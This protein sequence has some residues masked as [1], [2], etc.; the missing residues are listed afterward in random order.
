MLLLLVLLTT[1]AVA[2]S[3]NNNTL[4]S[5]ESSSHSLDT[6]LDVEPSTAHSN[7][8]ESNLLKATNESLLSD[9]AS[10]SQ[11]D[12]DINSATGTT[13]YLEKNYTIQDSEIA[14]Y[15]NGIIISK[16][17]IIIDGKGHTID[18]AGAVRIFDISGSGVTLKNIT[19]I[20][21]FKSNAYNLGSGI[22]WSGNS[23][24][25]SYCT[26]INN[27]GDNVQYP[28]SG[29]AI[30]WT[31]NDA[32][33]ERSSFINNRAE[34]GGAVYMIGDSPNI[35]FT[36]FTSNRAYYSGGAI[37]MTSANGTITN[38]N[39]VSNRG[40]HGGAIWFGNKKGEH[41]YVKNNVFNNNEAI[42]S[43]GSIYTDTYYGEISNN[44]FVGKDQVNIK[45]ISDDDDCFVYFDNNEE[46]SSKNNG[47][48]I[49]NDGR[50]KLKDNKFTNTI[51]NTN[52]IL[53][54][55]KITVTGTHQLGYDGNPIEWVDLCDPMYVK[56]ISVYFDSSHLFAPYVWLT[57]IYTTDLSSTKS[58]NYIVSE[59]LKMDD[60]YMDVITRQTKFDTNYTLENTPSYYPNPYELKACNYRYHTFTAIGD[61]GILGRDQ[62]MTNCQYDHLNVEVYGSYS[63]L[64]LAIDYSTPE[65]YSTIPYLG[66]MGNF[67]FCPEFDL[68]KSNPYYNVSKINFADGVV[69]NKTMGV[70][71]QGFIDG[72]NLSRM[73][74][75]EAD[76]VTVYGILFTFGNVYSD[77]IT[78]VEWGAPMGGALVWNGANGK[79]ASSRFEHNSYDY[80][81]H[82]DEYNIKRPIGLSLL[83]RGHNGTMEHVS[84]SKHA[85]INHT[86]SAPGVCVSWSGDNAKWKEITLAS[87]HVGTGLALYSDNAKLEDITIRNNIISGSLFVI[88]ADNVTVNRINTEANGGAYIDQGWHSYRE[89]YGAVLDI[90]DSYNLVINNLRSTRDYYSVINDE[91]SSIIIHNSTFI[92]SH[93]RCMDL[94]ADFG[95]SHEGHYDL[96]NITVD[97]ASY[98]EELIYSSAHTFN[99]I[100]IGE[101]GHVN[102]SNS[103]FSNALLWGHTY[104]NYEDPGHVIYNAGIIRMNNIRIWNIT[105]DTSGVGFYTENEAYL[106]NCSF[107]DIVCYPNEY[108]MH[109]NDLSY[110]TKFLGG[111]IYIKGYIEMN[112][113]HVINSN[114]TGRHG[115]AI[116]A[117]L[118]N[119]TI[120]NCTFFN[121]TGRYG[122]AIQ[123]KGNEPYFIVF[124]DCNFTHNHAEDIGGAFLLNNYVKINNCSF[125]ENTAGRNGIAIFID[126]GSWNGNVEISNSSFIHNEAS[127]YFYYHTHDADPSTVT[128]RERRY[129]ATLYIGGNNVN[130]T[131]SIF[132]NN[133]TT[134]IYLNGGDGVSYYNG[135]NIR[136]INITELNPKT[137]NK[138]NR[139]VIRSLYSYDKWGLDDYN[140]YSLYSFVLNGENIFLSGNKLNNTMLLD[141]FDISRWNY[142]IGSIYN[143]KPTI[144]SQTH[145][146][147]LNNKTWFLPKGY[148][149]YLIY[150]QIKDD[151]NNTIVTNSKFIFADN[152]TFINQKN[153]N[154]VG[155][156]NWTY[157]YSYGIYRWA[158]NKVTNITLLLGSDNL[159]PN[160]RNATFKYGVLYTL[161]DC[162]TWL[163]MLIDNT[164]DGGTLV[165][166]TSITFDPFFDLHEQNPYAGKINFTNGVLINKTIT[167]SGYRSWT[168]DDR[169]IDG[170][171]QAR[172]F[173]VIA[174][175][176]VLRDLS[177][178]N[179]NSTY[180]GAIYYDN[181]TNATL[182][183]CVFRKNNC[184]N[185]SGGAI[186]FNQTVNPILTSCDFYYNYANNGSGGAIYFNNTI[187]PKLSGCDFY[188]NY[189]INGSGG[190]VYCDYVTNL[191]MTNVDFSA[192]R[193]INGSGGA[194][195][196]NKSD[197][198]T[199]INN[200]E[201]NNNF[202]TYYGGA[203][204]AVNCNNILFDGNNNRL[205]F[206]SNKAA[207]GSA[208]AFNNVNIVKMYAYQS[209]ESDYSYQQYSNRFENNAASETGAF[210]IF[211]SSSILLHNIF[212]K[213]NKALNV[214]S[215]AI[216]N[217]KDIFINRTRFIDNN[218]STATDLYV[219]GDNVSLNKSAFERTMKQVDIYTG[220]PFG[221]GFVY[222]I[223]NNG[224]IN[225]TSFLRKRGYEWSVYNS[226]TRTY[227]YYYNFRH[228]EENIT[229]GDI[230]IWDGN[231]GTVSNCEFNFYE[232]RKGYQIVWNG[233][234][235]TFD[236]SKSSCNNTLYVA[237]SLAINDNTETVGFYNTSASVYNVGNISLNGNKFN[238]IIYNINGKITSDTYI[239]VINNKTYHTND[240]SFLLFT[241]TVDDM[242]N[243][244]ISNTMKV[245]NFTTAW[246]T[247]Y[248]TTH[249]YYNWTTVKGINKITASD[250]G[251]LNATVKPGIVVCKQ[252]VLLP[253]TINQT[254]EGQIVVINATLG[255][256]TV[257]DGSIITISVNGEEYNRTTVNNSAILTLYNLKPGLYK[258]VASYGGNASVFGVTNNTNFTVNLLN[259]TINITATNITFYG[260][261][262][263]LSYV[264]GGNVT[265]NLTG[266]VSFI[267]DDITYTVNVNRTSFD[268][269]LPRV[270]KFYITGIYSG[271][272][273]Y[274]GSRNITSCEVTKRDTPISI[275]N[276]E[277][278]IGENVTLEVVID[279]HATGNITISINGVETVVNISSDHVARLNMSKVVAGTYYVK[280]TYDGNEYCKA[281]FTNTT[282]IVTKKSLD[283]TLNISS[284]NITVVF[285]QNVTGEVLFDINGTGYWAKIIDGNAT[286]PMPDN[287]KP[288]WYNVTAEFKGD[289]IWGNIT[290]NGGFDVTAT[291]T[292]LIV[293]GNNIFAGD[294]ETLYI[295]MSP[296]ATGNVTLFINDDKI[297][298]F[299]NLTSVMSYTIPDLAIGK[300]DVRVEYTGDGKFA[301][302]NNITSFTVSELGGFDFIILVNDTYVGSKNNVTVI[303]PKNATGNITIEGYAPVKIVN[304]T[305]TIELNASYVPGRNNFVVTYVPDAT[306]E[307]NTTSKAAFYHVLKLNS[308]IVISNINITDN[309]ITLTVV[310]PNTNST[311]FV[312]GKTYNV[313]NGKAVI[314]RGDL[315]A[316]NH[317]VIATALEDDHY[318]SSNNITILTLPKANLTANITVDSENITVEFSEDV[319][320]EVLFDINGTH[321]WADII[322]NKAIIAI[323]DYLSPGKYN[324]TAIFKGNAE[325]NNITLYDNFT[326]E[327]MNATLIVIGSNIFVGDN[328]TLHIVVSPD[329]TGNITLYIND[330]QV[331]VFTELSNV[332]KYP[333]GNLTVGSYDVKVVYSGNNKY[334]PGEN[335]TS[336]TVFDLSDN[337][338]TVTIDDTYVG[339][340][341]NVT[342]IGPKNAT[343]N[344]SID[345]YGS[346]KLVDGKV[347]IEINGTVAGR[348]KVILNYVPDATSEYEATSFMGTFNVAKLNSTIV[349]SEVN[350]DDDNVTIV[351]VTPNTNSTIS[352]NG[353]KYNVSGGKVVIPRNELNAGNHTVIAT[354]LEDNIYLEAINATVFNIP[355]KDLTANITVDSENITVEFS[356]NIDGE[357]L[358]DINGTHIWAHIVNGKAIIPIPDTL[359][360]G[361]YNV[362]AIFKGND[363]YNNITLSD[364]FKLGKINSTIIP[365]ASDILLG[366]DEVIRIIISPN[367]T[368]KIDLYVDN[369]LADTFTNLSDVITYSLKNLE[370]GQHDI[371]VVYSGDSKYYGNENTTSFL[372]LE[373]DGFYFVVN[374]PDTPVGE[375]VN[376]TVLVPKN[377]TGNISIPGYD[378]VTIVDGKAVIQLN[379]SDDVGRK[380]LNVT[381]VPDAASEYN[382][383]SKLVN[384][385]IIKLTPNVLINIPDVIKKGDEV[386]VVISTE[387][388]GNVSVIIN[389]VEYTNKTIKFVAKEGN[390][391][392][393]AKT[394]ES[395]KYYSAIN[396]TTFNVDKVPVIIDV[397]IPTNIGEGEP[398]TIKV[399]VTNG[400]GIVLVKVDDKEYYVPLDDK[401]IALLPLDN[402]TAGNHTVDVIYLND[403]SSWNS[404]FN[405]SDV[406]GNSSKLNVTYDDMKITAK[407]PENA[408]GNVTATING[409][410]YTGKIDNGTA[411][412]DLDGVAPGT[413]DV[414]VSYM[415]NGTKVT[416]NIKITVPKLN[417]NIDLNVSNIFI[418][419]NELML[420][421]VTSGATGYVLITMDNLTYYIELNNS[422]GSLLLK[423]LPLGS[424]F[425]TATYVGDD[426]YLNS[427]TSANFTVT[428]KEVIVVTAADNQDIRMFYSDGTVYTIRFMENGKNVGAG[429]PVRFT[430]GGRTIDAVTDE[431]GVAVCP[432]DLPRGKFTITALYADN[433]FSNKIVV[434]NVIHAAKNAKIK[435]S[436]K[437]SKIKIALWG[438][439][440]KVIKKPKFKYA[441]KKKVSMNVGKELAGKSISIKVKGEYFTSTVSSKGKAT[442]KISSK[443]ARSMG[444]KSGK[445]YKARV[446]FKDFI[447]FVDK[448]VSV[449]FNGN[450]YNLRTNANGY[451]YFIITKDM[452][453]PLKK[454]KYVYTIRYGENTAQRAIKLK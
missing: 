363:Q 231:N 246:S 275:S 299:T 411:V 380:A 318:L 439:K 183:G 350:I 386:T 162:Y 161:P 420:V 68:N 127:C 305:A 76:N 278:E 67:I 270:G 369:V 99:I 17:N 326:I 143:K 393:L 212:F 237:G 332:L 139:T 149:D 239:T 341:T 272:D 426:V 261:K 8:K 441:G 210:Y 7:N 290:L 5:K 142:G 47:Y 32:I 235:G 271:D 422:Q 83:W 39:F 114:S 1:T 409:V 123:V 268:V 82:S 89:L 427:T 336:F 406:D 117:E 428:E 195:F 59:N 135:I 316:G 194:I 454:G 175:N 442:I 335:I 144:I 419:D 196:L 358:F 361:D 50:I 37:Y 203:I 284:S 309:N 6:N 166:P 421:N 53:S 321:I 141:S 182:S 296:D 100:N 314:P 306:S 75:V 433:A 414:L 375:K 370:A 354:A 23:G 373:V 345:G 88:N 202:A 226:T 368:G 172:I 392:I 25:V 86:E 331:K 250:V 277:L 41:T 398:F 60:G 430:I 390:Y 61:R 4:I 31:G 171:N 106:N 174:N 204:Y 408:T 252:L 159:N 418:G 292:T 176:T 450:I 80:Q 255:G 192:N 158:L 163:Q 170:L 378:P 10:F 92:D 298:T 189:A 11:L 273:Y 385:N 304:G 310:T 352:I 242:N 185:S 384:Y 315:K 208:I 322:G 152:D 215:L 394:S 404:S 71:I 178:L 131:N 435:K 287:L 72:R 130:V 407:V 415:D 405:V 248:N 285:S 18:A 359:N 145:V 108:N 447:R 269:I 34:F 259:T 374:V 84:F 118:C 279:S 410:D 21:A 65:W 379:A 110:T 151:N 154:I 353:K 402:L 425:V 312:N 109:L 214:A 262:T 85:S 257:D 330:K 128:P 43:G 377:A 157:E 74:V 112:N 229:D 150:V 205:S 451:A 364:V 302:A 348:N 134:L 54:R 254:N 133:D 181:V 77:L 129:A 58:T 382:S 337:L 383:T 232:V 372:V 437:K 424:Y 36:D 96:F 121:N 274:R 78:G 22:Y 253:I 27:I 45:T 191:T 230:I 307:Y 188:Y 95:S 122:G 399:N 333:I 90:R 371:K 381:Y 119:G 63:H 51:L 301:P 396:Y 282:F 291:N 423:K 56:P 184:T 198:V 93:N 416:K 29:G 103:S 79:L 180:G 346:H 260:N 30:Y 200:C 217:S 325:Y 13:I 247:Q 173:Y 349:V 342:V 365:I 238:N 317:T 308:T 140:D 286:I 440:S 155:M 265:G 283:A 46:T 206:S 137:T 3:D 26:F 107:D 199:F 343:G 179:G 62:G 327:K 91:G 98:N 221:S 240:T 104:I 388:D 403:G 249:N 211:N 209:R 160:L 267:I 19:F 64:Q 356:E 289:E 263:T 14:S 245:C 347:V 236:K 220:I 446:V 338:F 320:G 300:Y 28:T 280:A 24:K 429:K 340:K 213:T 201:F 33:I 397:E 38:C 281:N 355:R 35:T 323:P 52:T 12:S 218:A 126:D 44:K 48:I 81:N 190:A 387:S 395:A 234:N 400:E 66:I 431:N 57:K 448:D 313:T 319:D 165:L 146:T 445:K 324:V 73:M 344:I 97:R 329:A 147:F 70:D 2:A 256:I 69:V 251:L 228:G 219:D 120:R 266:T 339:G 225:N 20:N 295:I 241:K 55:V 167:I 401:G 366:N 303:V 453:K 412:I 136:L 357:V 153:N 164:T 436:K 40:D 193:A 222:W 294:N 288:G 16:N 391:T 233:L 434:K 187:T 168:L 311:I 138:V 243:T 101:K 124:E 334:N 360:P 224:V 297:H 367:A 169:T 113:S 94:G 293:I 449:D 207:N 376:V 148:E 115:G 197:N 389:G 9:S 177:L 452:V 116:Y 244:I 105:S 443:L 432:L 111:A 125:V 223:G 258:V 15:Q 413:Y 132:D 227:T 42:G 264:I 87:N 328:E 351:V 156:I 438:L 444:L 186:Y 276:K 216:L 362:T 49:K 102:I 417:S